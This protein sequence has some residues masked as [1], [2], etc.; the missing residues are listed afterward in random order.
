MN[1]TKMPLT[2]QSDTVNVGKVCFSSE[3][4]MPPNVPL[5]FTIVVGVT[6]KQADQYLEATLP[7]PI[8]GAVFYVDALKER[9]PQRFS[10]VLFCNESR[11]T[12][13][14]RGNLGYAGPKEANR[15]T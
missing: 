15:Q 14:P 9:Q 12:F 3:N 5:R 13:D 2:L 6:D 10:G 8:F 1:P 7:L 11:I 4:F